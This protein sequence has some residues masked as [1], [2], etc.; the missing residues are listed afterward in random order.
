MGRK[1]YVVQNFLNQI[2]VVDLDADLRSGSLERV[3]TS[4]GYDIP[5]TAAAVGPYLYAVN[6][7]FMTEPTPETD[8]AIIGVTR[9]SGGRH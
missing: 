7:R 6:A 1:L 9:H 8:Y 5:T 4:D 2:A 3:L